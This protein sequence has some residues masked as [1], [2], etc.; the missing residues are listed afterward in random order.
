M[1]LEDGTAVLTGLHDLPFLP[2]ARKGPVV[3]EQREN[4]VE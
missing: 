3:L 4:R 2:E 1:A